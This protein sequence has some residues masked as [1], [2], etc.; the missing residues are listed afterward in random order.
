MGI[1]GSGFV[2]SSYDL[3]NS[4]LNHQSIH[5]LQ[6]YLPSMPINE[7]KCS[8]SCSYYLY[9]FVFLFFLFKLGLIYL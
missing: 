6:L 9:Y 4:Q 1:D 8:C 7:I 3:E 5:Y 2:L